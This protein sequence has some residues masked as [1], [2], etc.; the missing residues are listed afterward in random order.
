MSKPRWRWK[1]WGCHECFKKCSM[2]SRLDEG[3]FHGS[4][5]NPIYLTDTSLGA[6]FRYWKTW[7]NKAKHSA[8]PSHLKKGEWSEWLWFH[9]KK[10][11]YSTSPLCEDGANF[12]VELKINWWCVNSQRLIWLRWF[13]WQLCATNVTCS[14]CLDS[15]RAPVLLPFLPPPWLASSAAP[16]GTVRIEVSV[17]AWNEMLPFSCGR[18]HLYAACYS[19]RNNTAMRMDLWRNLG[20]NMDCE[21]KWWYNSSMYIV[22][23]HPPT[24]PA[25]LLK[26]I[27]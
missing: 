25:V 5:I 8:H 13:C 23:V 26:A 9:H 6:Y 18:S 14:C 7:P 15:G 21:V 17:S 10:K 1:A 16:S 12:L 20:Q 2:V 27:N 11:S 19:R 22:T 4:H 3:Y 24:Y